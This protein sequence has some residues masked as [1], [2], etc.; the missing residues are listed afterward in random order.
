MRRNILEFLLCGLVVVAPALAAQQKPNSG[1]P[2]N[3]PNGTKGQA[4]QADSDVPAA[5]SSPEADIQVA[6]YYIHKGDSDAAIPRLEEAIR[7]KPKLAKPRLMLADV[8]EK[9]GDAAAAAKCYKEYL[10]AFPSAPDQRK[11]EKKIER[12]TGQ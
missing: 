4:E 9:K 12:L 11:I 3:S 1:P 7:L 6:S 2:G 5:P 10:Q 8:Y